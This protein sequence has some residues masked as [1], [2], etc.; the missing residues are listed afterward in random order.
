MT[1]SQ[2][3]FH[4]PSHQD[5]LWDLTVPVQL[6]CSMSQQRDGSFGAKNRWDKRLFNWDACTQA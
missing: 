2:F 6:V 5:T 3:A 4:N 1:A